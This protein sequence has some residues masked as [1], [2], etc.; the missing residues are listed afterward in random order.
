MR[1]LTAADT[2]LTQNT[3]FDKGLQNVHPDELS[4]PKPYVHHEQC[5]EKLLY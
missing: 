3:D 5:C 2:Y 1:L 4:D